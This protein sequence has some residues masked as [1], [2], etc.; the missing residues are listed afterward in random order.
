MRHQDEEGKTGARIQLPDLTSGYKRFPLPFS[1]LLLSSL[2]KRKSYEPSFHWPDHLVFLVL[3][4]S[5]G[6]ARRSV[7][8]PTVRRL[9]TGAIVLS[10]FFSR[11]LKDVS[12]RFLAPSPAVHKKEDTN[13]WMMS[14]PPVRFSLSFPCRAT[15]KIERRRDSE[16]YSDKERITTAR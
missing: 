11:Q 3:L 4:L 7:L 13:G 14:A 1:F 5:K 16:S 2:L 12:N 15:E 10:S 8:Q 6:R 9:Q